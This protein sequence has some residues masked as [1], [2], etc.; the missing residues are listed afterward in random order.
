VLSSIFIIS[1]ALFALRDSRHNT[2]ELAVVFLTALL[3]ILLLISSV[4]LVCAYFC[5]VGFSLNLY[6]L[7]FSDTTSGSAREAGIKYFYLSSLSAGLMLYGIFILYGVFGSATYLDIASAVIE[8]SFTYSNNSLIELG[9]TF[10]LFGLFFK[11]SAAPCHMW[12]PEVYDGA[13]N[14]V[15]AF[16]VL[17]VKI[18]VLAFLLFFLSL[19]NGFHE[20][21]TTK[22]VFAA[23]LSLILGSIGAVTATRTKKFLAYA[24][25][26]QMGF[27]LLGLVA[28][29]P[30]GYEATAIY[31]IFYV[32]AN[33][34]FL[35]I[36]L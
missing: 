11:L 24:S 33:I 6:V 27:L 9:L 35:Q 2:L 26:S 23:S 32:L 10:F 29:G 18:G 7:I 3:F 20:L 34:I 31:L 36:F 5:I 22:L 1:G 4:N 12:A 15:T 30:A 8:S 17:P 13:P 21:C 14:N 25:I 16:F 19:S 28:G